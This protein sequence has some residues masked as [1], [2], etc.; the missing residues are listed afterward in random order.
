[1]GVANSDG[2]P[3]DPLASRRRDTSSSQRD[4]SSASLAGPLGLWL[5]AVATGCRAPNKLRSRVNAETSPALQHRPWQQVPV[6]PSSRV[7]TRHR[8][9]QLGL[10]S[11]LGQRHFRRLQVDQRP[12]ERVLEKPVFRDFFAERVDWFRLMGFYEW[13]KVD[14]LQAGLLFRHEGRGR[15]CI[16]R[17]L[18]SLEVV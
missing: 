4:F 11:L 18:G 5:C 16:R 1:V 7:R 15:V 3:D 9:A 8:P 10:R 2:K 17:S 6:H 13:K 12:Y 14:R